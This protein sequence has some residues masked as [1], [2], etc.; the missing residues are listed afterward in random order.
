M[1]SEGYAS[2]RVDH[3]AFERPSGGV[4]EWLNAAVSKS[5]GAP[6]RVVPGWPGTLALDSR[7]ARLQGYFRRFTALIG[8]AALG[9]GT[10]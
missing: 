6:N 4:A 3:L 7:Y 5:V 1:R 8:F 10:A 2:A 9:L